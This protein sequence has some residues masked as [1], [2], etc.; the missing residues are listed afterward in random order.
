MR[1]PSP[2]NRQSD[3]TFSLLSIVSFFLRT[4][5]EFKRNI[6][7]TSYVRD[8]SS[9][10][11]V[12]GS[13]YI[14]R[15]TKRVAVPE[16][17]ENT[18][19]P[20]RIE[21]LGTRYRRFTGFAPKLKI[22]TRGPHRRREEF[23]IGIDLLVI[24]INQAGSC[25]FRRSLQNGGIIGSIRVNSP[26][27]DGSGPSKSRMFCLPLF[28][29]RDPAYFH[30]PSGLFCPASERFFALSHGVHTMRTRFDVLTRALRIRI[31][32]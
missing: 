8:A 17:R 18:T 6:V 26:L 16:F 25:S 31:D 10:V 3:S 1:T 2:S 11:S 15:G 4:T 12:V 20:L 5:C 7:N 22:V 23:S 13:R 14:F 21:F 27:V 28:Y 9:R 30:S 32:E 29:A 24:W 19:A